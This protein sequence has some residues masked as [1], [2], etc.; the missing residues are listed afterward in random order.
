MATVRYV[1]IHDE[2]DVRLPDVEGEPETRWVRVRNG[3]TLETT[4]DHAKGLV[5][6]EAWEPATKRKEV[7]TDG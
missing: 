7:K 4:A 5:V 1:G 2:V 6:S 3:G